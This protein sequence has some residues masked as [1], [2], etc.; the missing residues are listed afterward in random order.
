MMYMPYPQQ[1]SVAWCYAMAPTQNRAPAQTYVIVHHHHLHQQQQY[2]NVA[3]ETQ[4]VASY[5]Y[6][7]RQHQALA[8][9]RTSAAHLPVY[10][11]PPQPSF[12]TAATTQIKCPNAAVDVHKASPS[13]PPM[14]SYMLPTSD[15]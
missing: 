5:T 14:P 8:T 12:M 9:H 4:S 7:Q 3:A 2:H 1:Q 10:S 13:T 15:L 6:P 11:S